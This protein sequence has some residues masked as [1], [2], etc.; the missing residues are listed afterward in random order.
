MFKRKKTRFPTPINLFFF[1]K[2]G[3]LLVFI[4][5]KDG[6]CIDPLKIEAI[7]ALP[8]PTNVTELQI[9]QGKANFLHHFVCNYAERT[10]G[11]MRLLK[12]YTPFI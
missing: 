2:D 6:I 12:K 8:T 7:L 9:L 5:S 4:I 11:F 1:V 3:R 10:H